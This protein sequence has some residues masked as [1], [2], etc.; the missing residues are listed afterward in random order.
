MLS[1][2]A[3]AKSRIRAMKEKIDKLNE[4]KAFLMT[5]N[6]FKI[7]YMDIMYNCP[8]CRDTGI[9]DTGERCVCF[10]EKLGDIQKTN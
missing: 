4:E 1:G 10:A 8:L 6:N 9:Q 5:E 3:D 2:A 7:D